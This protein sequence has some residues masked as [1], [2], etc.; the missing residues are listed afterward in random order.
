MTLDGTFVRE[1]PTPAKFL[2]TAD[3]RAGVRNN[4]ALESLSPTPS[5]NSLVTAT[6]NELFQDGPAAGLDTGSP[7]RCSS[8]SSGLR[9]G[10]RCRCLARNR[11]NQR[12][13]SLG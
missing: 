2:S 5:G 11:R 10:A 1:I 6:E 13:A 3:Q 8:V 12:H 4:Q 7:V 9:A